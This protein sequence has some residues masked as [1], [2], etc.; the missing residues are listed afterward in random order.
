MQ[1]TL[2]RANPLSMRL[3]A[4]FSAIV[5]FPL[6]GPPITRACPSQSRSCWRSGQ[7]S[8]MVFIMP[9]ERLVLEPLL[10][11]QRLRQRCPHQLEQ[12]RVALERNHK[13]GLESRQLLQAIQLPRSL[14]IGV[15][16][17]F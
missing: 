9:A 12:G 14:R 11:E 13:L 2:Q 3:T 17:R 4:F 8:I 1:Q 7:I 5:V 15:M 16:N 10:P 6:L